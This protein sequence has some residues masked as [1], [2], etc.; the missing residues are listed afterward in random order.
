[1]GESPFSHLHKGFDVGF[2]EVASPLVVC[3]VDIGDGRDRVEVFGAINC[4][5]GGRPHPKWPAASLR[6]V[7]QRIKSRVLKSPNDCQ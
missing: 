3:C 5:V 6:L 4:Q 2:R 7:V 1:M